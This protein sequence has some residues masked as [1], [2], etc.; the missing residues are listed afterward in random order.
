M[1]E[2]SK[3]KYVFRVEDLARR[4]VDEYN[5]YRSPEAHAEI[6]EVKGDI[7]IVKFTGSF[8]RTCG[9]RDWVEDYAYVLEDLGVEA[10]LVEYIE[11]EDE[12]S[13]YRIGVF[14]VKKWLKNSSIGV[15]S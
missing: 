11:P 4:A 5:K 9:I 1:S 6:L 8:C 10:E 13:D 12:E 15:D 3:R 7:I 14:R 2:A